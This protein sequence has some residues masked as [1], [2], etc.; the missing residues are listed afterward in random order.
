MTAAPVRF[1]LRVAPGAA[2]SEI[3]GR[4]GEAWK[5]RVNAAPE[6]GKAN[7]AVLRLL[8]EVLAVPRRALTLIAG[9]GDRDKL[10]EL[11]G[12]DEVELERRLEA[13]GKGGG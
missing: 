3:V 2:R 5:I 7:E 12:L 9:H 1:R 8:A 11:E 6:R 10:V 13:A 4:H